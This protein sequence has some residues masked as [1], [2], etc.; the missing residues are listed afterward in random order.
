MI[1]ADG[2]KRST[3]VKMQYLGHISMVEDPEL[4]HSIVDDVLKQVAVILKRGLL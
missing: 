1:C 4:F 3:F 2:I